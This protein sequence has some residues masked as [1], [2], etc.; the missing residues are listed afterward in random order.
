[1][2]RSDRLIFAEDDYRVEYR[3]GHKDDGN[4]Q[5][6]GTL[7]L[8]DAIYLTGDWVDGESQEHTETTLR[9]A[10]KREEQVNARIYLRKIKK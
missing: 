9:C 6:H 8:R 5:G 1:M 7:T 2:V 10:Q 3:G 4:M